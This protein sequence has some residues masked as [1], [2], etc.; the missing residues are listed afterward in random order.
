MSTIAEILAR[1]A[2]AIKEKSTAQAA[3]DYL[4][5]AADLLDGGV[6]KPVKVSF[7]EIAKAKK[8]SVVRFSKAMQADKQKQIDDALKAAGWSLIGNKDGQKVYGKKD[9]PGLQLRIKGNSFEVYQGDQIQQ[10]K[11]ELTLL[12]NYLAEA[13]GPVTANKGTI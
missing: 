9:K 8:S 3:A 13:S 1:Q 4:R 10:A 11:T 2:E 6:N 12:K 5:K 7:A